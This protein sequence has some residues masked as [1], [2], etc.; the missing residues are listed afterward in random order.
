MTQKQLAKIALLVIFVAIYLVRG[1]LL[2]IVLSIAL[3]YILNPLTNLIEKPFPQKMPGRRDIAICGSFAAFIVVIVLAFA[4]IVP[5]MI[6]QFGAL[7]SNFPGYF[8]SVIDSIASSKQWYLREKLPP[9]ID[10]AV[11]DA[12]KQTLGWLVTFSQSMVANMLGMLSQLLGL[13]VIPVIVYFMLREQGNLLEGVHKLV[14]PILQEPVKEILEKT[15]LVLKSYVESQLIICSLIG[16]ITWIILSF[17]GVPFAL[18][19]A[20]IAAVT[21]LIPVI[22]P[23]IGGI[24]AVVL[25][26]TISPMTALYVIILYGTV[27]F[28]TGYIIAPKIMGDKLGIHPLTVILGVLILGN[29]IGVWGIFFAAPII[30]IL[31]II[32]LEII[33]T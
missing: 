2:P 9:Q 8:Q 3:F 31:K 30:A 13:V 28:V 26:A 16:I 1:V 32:Y 22:G 12:V 23:I 25:A 5:Q 29:L 18:V 20:I 11:L 21:E 15:A 24:P 6:S 33:K 4:Y 7:V 19:I 14:P 27:Q 10:T 17:L